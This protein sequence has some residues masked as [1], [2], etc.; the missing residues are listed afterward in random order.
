MA[1]AGILPSFYHYIESTRH[2]VLYRLGST[3]PVPI[4][5]RL[6]HVESLAVIDC[7]PEAVTRFLHP[8]YFPAM[9]RIHYL[10][11]GPS[12][13]NL[14]C[15]FGKN[16]DWIFPVIHTSYPFYD[17][18]VEA[19]WGRREQGLVGQYLVSHKWSEEK[20]W[21]DMYLPRRGIVYGDWYH[22][23]L[24]AYFHKKH[25]NGLNTPYPVRKEYTTEICHIPSP[26]EEGPVLDSRW[27]YEKRCMERM[28]EKVVLN[29]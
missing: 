27:L 1:Y 23:Q 21:F 8:N 6:P 9:R 12:D 17:R 19:G 2:L 11:A 22:T 5:L 29:L 24:M 26:M 28:F 4:G 15:R 7:T 3:Y 25:C 14:H 16:V 10:S 18:M 13:V 20:S